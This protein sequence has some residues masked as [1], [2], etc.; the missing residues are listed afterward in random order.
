MCEGGRFGRT[1]RGVVRR[2][3]SRGAAREGGARERVLTAG[4]ML[5]TSRAGAWRCL[6][7]FC[8]LPRARRRTASL[9]LSGCRQ[10]APRTAIQGAG[11]LVWIVGPFFC[12]LQYVN[13][14]LIYW[15]FRLKTGYS[16]V[17]GRT[18][19]SKRLAVPERETDGA[20]R[21]RSGHLFR[22]GRVSGAVAAVGERPTGNR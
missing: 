10:G 21:C 8:A 6:R 19:G 1:G 17:R 9:S 12:N 20:F 7:I 16:G 18:A 2:G 3:G 4:A 22:R 13:V 15:E 11:R 14:V 5:H